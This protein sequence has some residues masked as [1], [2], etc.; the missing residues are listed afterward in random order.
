M[1]ERVGGVVC[2]CWGEGS[3]QMAVTQ[4]EAKPQFKFPME[5]VECVDPSIRRLVTPFGED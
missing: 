5:S 2:V 1:N 4:N 3:L